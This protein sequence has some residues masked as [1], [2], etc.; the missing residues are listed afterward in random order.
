MESCF[1][2]KDT[3]LVSSCCAKTPYAGR[4]ALIIG[5]VAYGMRQTPY[6]VPQ[7]V[8]IGIMTIADIVDVVRRRH[9]EKAADSVRFTLH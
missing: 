6:A 8:E 7:P 9:G 1:F 5:V 2:E 3:R 4:S